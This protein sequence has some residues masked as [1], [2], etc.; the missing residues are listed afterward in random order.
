MSDPV[1]KR[2]DKGEAV[3]RLQSFLNRV[4]AMLIADGDFGPATERGVIY[5]QDCAGQAST[6]VADRSLWGW[7]KSRPEPFSKLETNGVAF[8]ASEET[9]GLAYYDLHTRWPHY[10]GEASGITIGVGYDLRWNTKQDF[11]ATWG[12]RLPKSVRVELAKDI[13]KR[14]TKKRVAEL[15]RA[16]IEVPFESAWTVFVE[17]MLPRFYKNTRTIYPGLDRLPGLCRSVLVSLVFN[18]GTDLEGRRRK[19]MKAIQEIL[20]SAR[21]PGLGKAQI[22]DILLGIEDEIVS[23]KRLWGPA[24][25]LV[26]RRQSEAN[27]WRLGLAQW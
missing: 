16:G 18:R 13:G 20:E 8:I 25:G 22:K 2:S 27:L 10:P 26:K 4:G 7:L 17:R 9:G 23:M 19:E 1:L 6:G 3:L 14:G 21:Q 15:K 24:S 12:D 11:L 5:A